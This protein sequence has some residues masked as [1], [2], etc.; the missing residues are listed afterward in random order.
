MGVKGAVVA[1]EQSVEDQEPTIPNPNLTFFRHGEVCLLLRP[2]DRTVAAAQGRFD[3]AYRAALNEILDEVELDENPF[4]GP[5][6]LRTPVPMDR[7]AERGLRILQTVNVRGWI[8]RPSD[9]DST[10]PAAFER[11]LG[12]MQGMINAM[13]RLNER[14]DRTYG[15]YTLVDVSPNWTAMPF[16][17]P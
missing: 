10:T 16:N 14:L 13:D 6:G 7:G 9:L 2:R 1:L 15:D 4:Q 17:G 12:A 11:L 5:L 3:T 8:P